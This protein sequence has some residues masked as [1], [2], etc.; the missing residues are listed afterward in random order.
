MN[1]HQSLAMNRVHFPVTTLGYGRRVA[2]WTQGCSIRCPGCVSRD[3]WTATPGQNIPL[4]E[5][6]SGVKPWLVRADGLTISGGEPFDQP[7]ALAALLTLARPFCS[8]DI[9]VYT[10]FSWDR[11]E[12][13]FREI[14]RLTDAVVS[15][16]YRPRSG[17]TLVWRGSD[18]QQF[19]LLT[20]LAE[21]RYGPD[22]NRRPWPD[23]RRLDVF[24]DD[25]QVWLAGIPRPSDMRR[26]RTLL[27]R[28]GFHSRGSD[29]RQT[30]TSIRA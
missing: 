21:A 24:M 11:I 9:L 10:G 29:Q 13:D 20:P 28:R 12:N 23:H 8:G 16:P 15:E 4:K 18:N 30:S 17:A 7:G 3:T 5:V 1:S 25:G 14:I 19:H 6:I 2:L 22:I 26:V 27:R